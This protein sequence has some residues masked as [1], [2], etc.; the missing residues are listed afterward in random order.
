MLNVIVFSLC[1]L[2][3]CPPGAEGDPSGMTASQRVAS[4][5]VEEYAGRE[6]TRVPPA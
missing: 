4:Q 2:F 3:F 6:Y 5:L 1:L